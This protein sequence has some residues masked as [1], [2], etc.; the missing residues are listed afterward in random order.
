MIPWHHTDNMASARETLL[1]MYNHFK[2]D[3]P[4]KAF[5]DSNCLHLTKEPTF[6]APAIRG[7]AKKSC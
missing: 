3:S 1:T 2:D 7:G 6:V 4:V 5:L